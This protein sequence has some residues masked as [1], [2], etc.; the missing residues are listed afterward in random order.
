MCVKRTLIS[1]ES[2]GGS[3]PK[4]FYLGFLA[5]FYSPPLHIIVL[6]SDFLLLHNCLYNSVL[7]YSE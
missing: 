2:L 5:V 1:K 4:I 7:L 3:L 6:Y